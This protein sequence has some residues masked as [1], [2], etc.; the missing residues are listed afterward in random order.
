MSKSKIYLDTSVI[1]HLEAMDTQEKMQDTLQLWQELK[2]GQYI[3]TISDLTL[4]E[5]TKCP[6]PKRTLLFKYLSQIDYEEIQET[7][8]T[9]TLADEYIKYGVLNAK[10][11]DDCRHIAVATIVGCKYIISWNFKHFVNIKTINK[12][13]AVNKLLDYNE[14]SILPPSMMLEGEE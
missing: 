7:L 2:K 6:E 11:R 12:V 13:Q 10:S 14:I 4:A 5:L 9:I 3:V 8:E 1:S